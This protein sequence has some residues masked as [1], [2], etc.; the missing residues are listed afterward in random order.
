MLFI[1]D[2]D[3]TLTPSR[4]GSCGE[5]SFSLL[6]G[7]EQKCAALQAE[8]NTLAIASNQS[9]DRDISAIL[10]QLTWTANRL[11][12]FPL[13]VRYANTSAR[14]KPKPDM[15]IE[16]IEASGYTAAD[17][18]FVGD[19]ETDRQA[20]EAAGVTFFWANEFFKEEKNE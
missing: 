6:P 9:K 19:Q 7:V 13:Y 20:A 14:R 4:V 1:F 5:F 10:T 8:R 2:A 18:V 15:L 12:I 3:G 17:T 11:G 16:L